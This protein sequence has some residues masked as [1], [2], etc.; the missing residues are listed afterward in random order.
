MVLVD[1]WASW[2]PP[3]LTEFPG[4]NALAQKYQGRGF[5]ILGVNVDA[6]HEEIKDLKTATPIVRHALIHAGVMWPNI[7]NDDG[8]AGDIALAY[9]VESV[10]ANVLIGVDG[11]VIGVSIAGPELEAAVLKALGPGG[12]PR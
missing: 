12:R 11:T 3:C 6:H 2:C 4:L 7:L 5:E 8:N 10:P 9:G 1:F